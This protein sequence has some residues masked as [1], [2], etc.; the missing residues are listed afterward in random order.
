MADQADADQPVD[1]AR[2]AERAGEEDAE[3]VGQHR[4]DEQHGRPVVHL[5][6][7][8]T[9]ADVEGQA[10]VDAYASDIVQSAQQ[11]VGALVLDLA[12]STA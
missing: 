10:R 3:A 8:Q 6:H 2:L 1:L 5:P 12:P 11:L 4:G 7:Q 9:A